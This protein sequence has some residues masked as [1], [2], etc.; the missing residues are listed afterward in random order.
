MADINSFKAE[1]TVPLR[2]LHPITERYFGITVELRSLESPSVKAVSNRHREE[3]LRGGR[4]KI[5]ANKLDKNSEELLVAAIVSWTFETDEDGEQ[6]TLNDDPNPPCNDK[7]KLALVRSVFGKQIDT[8]LDDE[9][10]FFT[11][12]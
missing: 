10:G 8:A 3:T 9:K 7:N 11:V 5:S 1:G 6:A 12:K 4:L 2:L